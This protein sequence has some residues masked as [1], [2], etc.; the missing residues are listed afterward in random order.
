[1]CNWQKHLPFYR[2]SLYFAVFIFIFFL[3]KCHVEVFLGYVRGTCM[4]LCSC[5]CTCLCVK[6]DIGCLPSR[7]WP[8]IWRLNSHWARSSSAQPLSI[9]TAHATIFSFLHGCRGSKYRSCNCVVSH[10]WTLLRTLLSLSY[11]Q[12][13]RFFST[14]CGGYEH[15]IS[16]MF[17]HSCLKIW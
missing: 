12:M 17:W 7:S 9:S 14:I 4:C 6:V 8:Y 10:L 5:V 11:M 2:L 13:S 16:A 3:K 15:H 1:M